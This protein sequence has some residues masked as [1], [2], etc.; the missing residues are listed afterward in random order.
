MDF[1]EC[2][3]YFF[4][5]GTILKGFIGGL[6]PCIILIGIP[7]YL[8]APWW[9]I[10]IIASISIGNSLGLKRKQMSNEHFNM[11]PFF[12]RLGMCADFIASILVILGLIGLF[13]T[14]GKF[15]FSLFF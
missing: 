6:I 12:I 1:W 10:C 15:I 7:I 2:I 3:I 5:T 4:I 9:Y 13:Y 11:S 14:L 8:N